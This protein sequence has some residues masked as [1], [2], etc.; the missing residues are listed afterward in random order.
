MKLLIAIAIISLIAVIGSRMTF[1][2]RRLPLGVRSI[3]LT[4]SE[5][6][7]IG[8]L[9][10]RMGFDILDRSTLE[11]LQ[12]FL[13][14]GLSWIGFLF[15]V[16]FEIRFMK[17]LPRHYFSIT[18]IQSIITTISISGSIYLIVRITDAFS[19][20]SAL[21][22][23][24]MLGATGACSAQSAIAIVNRNY[25]I[26][27]RKL[28][29]LLRYITSVDGLFSLLF[30]MFALGLAAGFDSGR[31]SLPEALSWLLLAL[32]TGVVPALILILLSRV[33]FTQQEFLVFLIG[34]IMFAGGLA[35]HFDQSPLISGLVC[36]ILVANFCRHRLRAMEMVVHAEK[37]IYIILLLF[38]GALWQFSPGPALYVAVV[39]LITRM[40]GK[41][42]GLE[43][44]V[45]V[46]KPQ[47][48]TPA[49]LGLGLLSEGGL[50]VA[51]ILECCIFY[52]SF[53]GPLM[54][55]II[56]AILINELLGP[57]LLLA[58]FRETE[59]AVIEGN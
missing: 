19:A 4:G 29:D 51:I 18:A 58:Q 20:F 36:G 34:S 25:R 6:I 31:F 33:R 21:V 30:L 28:L 26:K 54:T 2:N 15:G 38:L 14:F 11:Q 37:S 24:V 48:K 44:A 9:L 42:L 50:A 59:R 45:R 23:A 17:K 56:P 53:A 43:V 41:V 46:F 8:I 57:R 27:E 13:I 3:L 12:P 55:V 10:G 22:F 52:P 39:Y 40:A 35:N 16:Q 47:F 1:L 7:L 49:G 32:F 5:Y